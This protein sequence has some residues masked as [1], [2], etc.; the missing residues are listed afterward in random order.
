[1]VPGITSLVKA[2]NALKSPSYM[3]NE[4]DDL[5]SCL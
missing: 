5:E 4:D 1:M 3:M 2:E